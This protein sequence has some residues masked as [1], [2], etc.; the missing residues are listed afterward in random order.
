MPPLLYCCPNTG[1]RVHG[2]VAEEATDDNTFED[3]TCLA[4]RQ[5][6]GAATTGALLGFGHDRPAPVYP[7]TLEPS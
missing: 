1:Y 6:N 7:R 4:R 3:V 5:I 2:F